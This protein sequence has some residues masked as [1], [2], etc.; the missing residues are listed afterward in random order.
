MIKKDNYIG[1]RIFSKILKYA[2][3]IWFGGKIIDKHYIPKDGK[4][5]LAGNHLSNFDAYLLFASTNRPVHF[6]A[7]KELFEGNFAWFFKMMH[8]IP[9]DRKNKNPEARKKTINILNNNK[10]IGIF[11]EGTYHKDDLLLPFKPGAVNFALLANAP[12][13]PFAIHGSFKFRSKPIIKFGEPIYIDK[14]EC[15]DK[16]LYLE[17][18]VR[19]MLIELKDNKK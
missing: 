7:K 4:C 15:E 19:N 18:V 16:V 12:I 1:Y 17:N 14:I 3:L 2:G 13:I 11:P 5:I 10:I 9:V 8:L 6:I